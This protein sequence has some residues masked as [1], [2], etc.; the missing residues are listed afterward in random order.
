MP[1]EPEQLIG[2]RAVTLPALLVAAWG[3]LAF[4]GAYPWASWPL[5]WGAAATGV[6]GIASSGRA[7]DIARHGVTFGILG[8]MAAV[9][10]Q[11]LPLSSDVIRAVSPSTDWFVETWTIVPGDV[12]LQATGGAFPAAPDGPRVLSLH[13]PSTFRALIALAALGLLVAGGMAALTTRDARR[14]ALGLL[15]L[16]VVVALIALVQRSSGDGRIYTVWQPRF[17]SVG[18]GPFV[19]RNHFAGW[20]TMAAALGLGYLMTVSSRLRLRHGSWRDRL[21]RLSSRDSESA[22]LAALA[23]FVMGLS[24]VLTASRSGVGA[25]LVA[26]MLVGVCAVRRAVIRSRGLTAAACVGG[27]ALGIIWVGLPAFSARFVQLRA[28]ESLPVVGREELW[29]DALRVIRTFPV[30]GAGLGTYTAVTPFFQNSAIPAPNEAHNDYLQLVAEGGILVGIPA[31]LLVALFVREVRREFQASG[32]SAASY[33]LRV[34]AVA[35]LAAIAVQELVD[36]SLQMPGNAVLFA[37]LCAIA[38]HRHD[39]RASRVLE[40]REGVRHVP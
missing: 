39:D 16:G 27:L 23:L 37:L 17:G 19:N 11:L 21:L 1:G 36:F 15:A 38:L 8:V 10:L 34:G 20:M 24:L 40:V 30:A 5:L 25:F 9:V 35:G 28:D 2:S 14:L 4:G 7:Q 22:L 29:R 32:T 6:W 33:W 3:V 13:P 18:F 31:L 26:F 12:V